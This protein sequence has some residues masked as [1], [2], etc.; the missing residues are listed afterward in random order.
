MNELISYKAVYR[1]ALGTPGLLIK[2][3]KQMGKKEYRK[4]GQSEKYKSLLQSYNQ[5][6]QNAASQHLKK[7][8]V[9]DLI[10]AAPG[11]AWATLKRMGA[12]PGECGE[13]GNFSMTMKNRT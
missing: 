3:V 10:D 4:N 2:K 12:Q 8:N 11:K 6:C 5:K 1:T 13:D 9:T 7:K